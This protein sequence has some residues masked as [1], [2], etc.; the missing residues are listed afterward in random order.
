[1][2]QNLTEAAAM[3]AKLDDQHV[4][5]DSHHGAFDA[6]AFHYSVYR[7][8]TRFLGMDGNLEAGFDLPADWVEGWYQMLLSNDFVNPNTGEVDPRHM[9]GT[10]NQDVFR[11]PTISQG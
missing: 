1:M 5:R 7:F 11:W 6:A 2:A 8:L 4:M 10:A 9:Y 3:T